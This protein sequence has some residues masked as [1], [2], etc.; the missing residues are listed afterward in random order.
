MEGLARAI[1]ATSSVLRIARGEPARSRSVRVHDREVHA[2]DVDVEPDARKLYAYGSG[3]TGAR[4]TAP[5]DE[6]G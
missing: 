4:R 3:A 5:V 2:V 1:L 6:A